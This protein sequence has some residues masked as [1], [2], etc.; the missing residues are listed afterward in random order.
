MPGDDAPAPEEHQTDAV[1]ED[2]NEQVP[3]GEEQTE[4]QGVENS[5]EMQ[6]MQDEQGNQ[7]MNPNNEGERVEQMV[8]ILIAHAY[9]FKHDG[10]QCLQPSHDGYGRLQP[11]NGTDDAFW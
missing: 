11:C 9:R 2:T 5:E 6:G 10:S 3:Q 1:D 8:L 7:M 4:D